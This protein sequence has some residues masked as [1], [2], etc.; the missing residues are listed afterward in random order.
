MAIK[1]EI[2]L[3]DMTADELVA[4]GKAVGAKTYGEL[5]VAFAEI[6]RADEVPL[7]WFTAFLWL[8]VRKYR[9]GITMA[10]AG[11]MTM[12]DIQ[13][14]TEAVTEAAKPKKP[15]SAVASRRAQIARK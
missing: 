13:A 3:E 11:E 4:L 7:D 8:S 10:E 9:P 2:N 5:Q 15:K 14:I 12:A 1:A 6:E